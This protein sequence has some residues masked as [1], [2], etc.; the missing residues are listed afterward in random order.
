MKTL[1]ICIRSRANTCGVSFWWAKSLDC[2]WR[3]MPPWPLRPTAAPISNSTPIKHNLEYR[4]IYNCSLV[5][6]LICIF[7]AMR[8]AF[9]SSFVTRQRA[10]NHEE[11]FRIPFPA[12]Q[13]GLASEHLSNAVETNPFYA[14][15]AHLSFLRDLISRLQR[16]VNS[17]ANRS[18][19]CEVQTA[20]M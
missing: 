7:L 10:S 6:E 12:S 14:K 8:V 15:R 11:A 13:F 2:P 1:C 4:K 9:L 18:R 3:S 5:A 16:R 17:Q 19:R 20:A